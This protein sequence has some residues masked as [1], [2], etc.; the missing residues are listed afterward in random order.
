MRKVSCVLQ[1][2]AEKPNRKKEKNESKTKAVGVWILK[3]QTWY[4]ILKGDQGFWY[5][6]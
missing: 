6:R 4:H 3:T 1:G 2:K 5:R